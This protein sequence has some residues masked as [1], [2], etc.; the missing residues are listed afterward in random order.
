MGLFS[1]GEAL[2]LRVDCLLYRRIRPY[3][4]LDVRRAKQYFRK[5]P[6]GNNSSTTALSELRIPEVEALWVSQ[7]DVKDCFY[8]LRLPEPFLP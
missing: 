1:F 6:A 3:D 5:A 8:R 4:I 7:V 2:L